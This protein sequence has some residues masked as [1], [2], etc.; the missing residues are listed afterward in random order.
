MIRLMN[1]PNQFEKERFLDSINVYSDII[2]EFQKLYD[3]TLTDRLTRA[4]ILN[5]ME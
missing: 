1:D 4:K 2:E 5:G 3:K